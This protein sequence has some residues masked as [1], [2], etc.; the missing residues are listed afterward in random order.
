MQPDT[1]MQ[2]ALDV[3]GRASS[4]QGSDQAHSDVLERKS[5]SNEAGD[6]PAEDQPMTEPGSHAD[7]LVGFGSLI[8]LHCIHAVPHEQSHV[9]GTHDAFQASLAC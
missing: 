7:M 2:D 3:A 1:G 5:A 4:Q 8:I 9:Y 6:N